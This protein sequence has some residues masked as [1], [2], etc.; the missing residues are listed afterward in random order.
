V[1]EPF[2][3][4]PGESSQPEDV[5]QEISQTAR[6]RAF[7]GR[8]KSSA[9]TGPK[10]ALSVS[11]GLIALLA[12][13]AFWRFSDRKMPVPDRAVSPA[14]MSPA[15]SR[16]VES[17][18]IVAPF[19][20]QNVSSASGSEDQPATLP[21]REPVQAKPASRAQPPTVRTSV[22][23]PAFEAALQQARAALVARDVDGAKQ[24]LDTAEKSLPGE[25]RRHE[26]VELRALGEQLA[27]FLA[28]VRAG[29]QKYEATEE[30]QWDGNTAAVIEVGKDRV[31]LFI[32][33]QPRDFSVSNM[34]AELALFFA[35][36]AADESS[37]QAQ[38]FYGA[39]HV[40]DPDGDR[41]AARRLWQQARAADM[42][43]DLLLPLLDQP[44][45]SERRQPVPAGP[46]LEAARDQ[47]QEPLAE[48]ILAA[49]TGP[50]KSRL[51]V[52][53][54]A[55]GR[56]AQD[57]TQQ[58]AAFDEAREW[59]IS[60]G[61]PATALAAIDALGQTFAVDVL[62]LKSEAL[63]ASVAGSGSTAA[64]AKAASAAL[65]LSDEAEQAGRL[66]LAG[67]LADTAY[68]AARKARDGALIRQAHQRRQALSG[69]R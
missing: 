21:A 34:P 17:S 13:I 50:Q 4:A 51:A 12:A 35:R 55:M 40:V 15:A 36:A 10:V 29:L 9:L 28:A 59:A 33:G 44:P 52:R 20:A 18:P 63:G 66:E 26:I 65:A 46:A 54:L 7:A 39:F 43:V 16:P 31:A 14:A 1:N 41:A 57:S 62:V 67:T 5:W 64:A 11:G 30:I 22:Q 27:L 38:V 24:V 42:P 61:D 68:T 49:K 53:L 25:D 37:P 3:P 56:A 69:K 6:R 8:R 60:A 19:A 45:L 2:D 58:Y 32:E 23:S 48:V 47:V